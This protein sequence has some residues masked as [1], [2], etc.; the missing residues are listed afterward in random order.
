M[1][2]YQNVI[3]CTGIEAVPVSNA[4][5]VGTQLTYHLLNAE[6]SGTSGVVA[7]YVVLPPGFVHGTHRHPNADQVLIPLEGPPFEF[8]VDDQVSVVNVGEIGVARRNHWHRLAN[9]SDEPIRAIVLFLGVS[10]IADAGYESAADR[11]LS[12]PG[13]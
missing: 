2:R 7:D 13:T 12:A 3:S 9:R 4:D 5:M 1:H 11:E 6:L 8:S 10:T